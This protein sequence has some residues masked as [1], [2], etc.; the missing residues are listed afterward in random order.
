MMN[1]SDLK[2]DMNKIKIYFQRLDFTS[3]G[4]TVLWFILILMSFA[5]ISVMASNNMALTVSYWL[6]IYPSGDSPPRHETLKFIGFMMSGVLAA[7]G[8][9]AINRRAEAQTE[10]A[11]AQSKAAE[12]QAQTAETQVKNNKLIEEGHINERFKSAIENLGRE[13]TMAR[14]SSFYQF[15]YLAKGQQD[16]EFKKSIFEILCAHLRN[17]TQEKLYREETG[18][19]T[20]T[21]ECQTLLNILFKSDDKSVFGKFSANL[22]RAYLKNAD[23]SGVA[24]LNAYLMSA[25]LSGVNFVGAYLSGAT[26]SGANLSCAD[27]LDADLPGAD[28]SRANL[29]EANLMSA[30][31]SEAYLFRTDLANANLSSANLSGANLIDGN[32]ANANF[33]RAD[34]LN[35]NF[36]AQYLFSPFCSASNFSGAIFTDADLSGAKLIRT[37]L[38]NV[39]LQDVHSIN[40]ADFHGAKVG[41]REIS[42]EDLPMD[43]GRYIAPWANDE[44]WN[45]IKKDR[46]NKV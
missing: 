40:E 27:F 45:Q 4:P 32:F 23:L 22:H 43:K 2:K 35:T 41:D 33:S 30:N 16:T 36:S 12:A 13:N 34:L 8:A 28:L 17:M 1:L 24:L 7:I 11:K 10:S 14:I 6:G 18:K 44:F 21:E 19:D 29:S 3:G 39:E 37:Q 38:E 25:N 26:L 5:F 31:L 46:K 15:Y 20:P 9:I 42:P